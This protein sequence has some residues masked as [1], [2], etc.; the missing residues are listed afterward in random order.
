MTAIMRF[1]RLTFVYAPSGKQIGRQTPARGV[2]GFVKYASAACSA[3]IVISILAGCSNAQVRRTPVTDLGE[4]W[5]CEMNESRDDW[6]CVQDQALAN[7][8]KPTRLPTDP[9]EPNPFDEPAPALPEV[10]ASTEGLANPS[11]AINF[12]AIAQ[13]SIRPDGAAAVMERS[14]EHF[15][16]QIAITETQA[17]ADGFIANHGLEDFEGLIT[18]ELAQDDNIYYSVLLGVYDNFAEAQAAVDSRPEALADVQPR[19]RPLATIQTGITEAEA[20]RIGLSN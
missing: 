20:L 11:A 6:D 1:D 19:I 17:L 9:V 15:A 3:L 18:L 8:P 13:A 7:N 4:G 16:V 14:P 10:T 12:D 2:G 5:F